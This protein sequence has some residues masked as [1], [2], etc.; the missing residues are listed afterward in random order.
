MWTG[1]LAMR[2][3]Y[4]QLT[5]FDR[6]LENS[7]RVVEIMHRDIQSPSWA[8]KILVLQTVGGQLSIRPY[9]VDQI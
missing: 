4:R 7:N 8:R 9:R 3:H 1:I 2:R 6:G 5:M